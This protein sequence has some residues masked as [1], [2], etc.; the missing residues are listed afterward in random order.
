[1][2]WDL[3]FYIMVI[4]YIV[5]NISLFFIMISEFYNIEL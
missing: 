5:K 2:Q 4:F 1:M 3:L